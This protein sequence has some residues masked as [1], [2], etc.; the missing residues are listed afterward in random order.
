M[1]TKK[2]Q[3]IFIRGG[4]AFDEPGQY[5]EY[6][7][8]RHFNPYK[9]YR[10]WRDWIE[11]ALQDEYD[12]IAP[13]MPCKKNAD[14]T[15]WQIWFEKIFPY[16]TGEPIILI[17]QSLGASFLIKWLSENKFP[18]E[19]AQLHLVSSMFESNGLIGE[20]IGDFKSDV[21]LLK[22]VGP[23][24][25]TIYFYHSKD[26]PMVP[27]DH[28]EKFI[29]HIQPTEFL[30]FEHRGHFDQPAIPELFNKIQELSGTYEVYPR[31]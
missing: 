17:G 31:N 2:K 21:A 28:S 19:I 12:M 18:T 23:Q 6:L 8:K 22:N 13:V 15:A 24:A 27:F 26:D 16:L 4:E 25:D 7:R 11:W 5:H 30:V 1:D 29:E 10:S 3:I 9:K 14:Y 20:G